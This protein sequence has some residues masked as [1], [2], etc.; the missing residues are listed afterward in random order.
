MLPSR[1]RIKLLKVTDFLLGGLFCWLLTRWLSLRIDDHFT[2]VHLEGCRR[3]LLIRPGGIGDM[4]V[5]LPA[6]ALLKQRFPDAAMD[7]ICEKRNQAVLGLMGLE[8]TALP[9]DAHPLRLLAKLLRTR[10][11]VAVDT[12]QFHHFSAV[13]A[14]LSGAP[15]RVGF[16]INPY[17]NA[18]YTHL[19]NYAPDGPEL[20]QFLRL[21]KPLGIRDDHATLTGIL[22]PYQG[23]LP[24]SC[25][26]DYSRVLPSE[27]FVV[28]HPC[29]SSVYKQWPP[30]KFGELAIQLHRRHSL[31][32]VIVG[33][34]NDR[35]A[36]DLILAQ[37][38]KA[39]CPAFSWQGTLSL[40]ETTAV[41]ARGRLFV[42]TDSALAHLAVALG[43]PTV[44][45]FGSS[46][47]VKWGVVDASH[48]VVRS[49]LPCSP[50]SIFGYQKPCRRVVCMQQITVEAAMAECERVLRS[51]SP[52]ALLGEAQ[53]NRF[54]ERND[55]KEGGKA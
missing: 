17:R 39:G 31:A 19:V 3:I 40:L 55:N 10:Y 48:A 51:S 24:P 21:L 9:Y 30:D 12:E 5:L 37:C 41:L 44:V 43:R 2:P 46:D 25:P 29:A 4:V 18:L 26:Q 27:A 33:D 6:I 28:L 36:G 52:S 53:S 38:R 11:D 8:N 34:Q 23:I 45:L 35:P 15:V 14:A 47:S 1:I 42:G 16:K 32:V 22:A 54:S 13:F 7:I 20:V 50:C 49:D